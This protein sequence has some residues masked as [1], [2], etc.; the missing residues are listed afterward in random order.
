[1]KGMEG[2]A[3]TVQSPSAEV[4]FEGPIPLILTITNHGT[5]AVTIPSDAFLDIEFE[6]PPG[7][8]LRETSGPRPYHLLGPLPTTTLA[9]GQWSS[10]VIYVHDYFASITP[11]PTELP[12]TVKLWP[13]GGAGQ[14]VVLRDVWGFAVMAPDPEGFETRIKAIQ[15]HIAAERSAEQRLELYK[16]VASLAHPA[17]IPLFLEALLDPT[18]QVFHLTARRRLVDLAETYGKLESIIQYL[19][20]YGSRYDAEFFRLWQQKQVRLSAEEINRL[21]ESSS[22]WTRLF[23]LEYYRQQYNRQGL[24]QSLKA[25]LEELTER[26]RTLENTQ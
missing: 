15:R 23:C 14:P 6:S 8:R 7:W 13:Q 17:L 4:P 10:R 18:V 3:L 9:P 1:M 21:C 19:I 2:L 5:D 20:N 16:S 11:G 25:E 26:V 24:I 22:L 12:V